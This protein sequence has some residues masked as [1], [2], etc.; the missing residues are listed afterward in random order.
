VPTNNK[1]KLSVKLRKALQLLETQYTD[2]QVIEIINSKTDKKISTGYFSRLKNAWNNSAYLAS[3][4]EK[5]FYKL[6]KIIDPLLEKEFGHVWNEKTSAYLN[7]SKL[8]EAENKQKLSAFIGVWIGYSWNDAYSQNFREQFVNTFKI[9]I[10][11][12]DNIFCITEKAEFKSSRFVLLENSRIILELTSIDANRKIF[13]MAHIGISGVEYIRTMKSVKC[14]YLDSGY[15]KVKAGSAILQRTEIPFDE[16][17]PENKEFKSLVLDNPSHK[18]F[19]SEK[20]II[21]EN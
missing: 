5:I 9:N 19:L 3:A 13:L 18:D 8:D 4:T 12:I 2:K 21:V 1:G 10:T 6:F 11:D 17:K 15:L 14:V 16:I 20:Q 7:E